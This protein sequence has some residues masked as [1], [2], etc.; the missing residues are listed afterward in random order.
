ENLYNIHYG[1]IH[2]TFP[3]N[4]LDTE[5]NLDLIPIIIN[6]KIET[7]VLLQEGD[8]IMA[9]ASEDYDGV[10]QSVELRNIGKKKIV[11]GT[12]TFALRPIID[13]AAKYE[14][15]IFSAFQTHMAIKKIATGISVYCLSKSNISQI[16]LPNPPLAEQRSI[17]NCL[18]TWD[19]G[20]EKLTQ[21]IAAKKQQKK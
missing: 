14:R 13:F 8:L 12:H 1:D 9:D 5:K 3:K 11:S 21:L 2:A 16:K 15:Y 7:P 19:A 6:P 10:G 18:S 20:I 4:I 17:A